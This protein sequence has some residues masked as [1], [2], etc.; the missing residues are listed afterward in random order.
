ML[1][2]RRIIAGIL[3]VNLLAGSILLDYTEVN[4][5]N[6]NTS[7]NMISA[8]NS[9]E[10]SHADAESVSSSEKT[11]TENKADEK[12][13]TPDANEKDTASSNSD[14]DLTN[15]TQEE[16]TTKQ[17]PSSE[18]AA[19]DAS[20]QASETETEAEAQEISDTISLNNLKFYTDTT[21]TATITSPQQ[22][23]LL[24]HCAQNEIQNK[25]ININTTGVFNLSTK[26]EKGTDL[27]EYLNT[28][29]IASQDYTYLGL[30]STDSPFKGTITGQTPAIKTNTTLFRGISSQA[31]IDNNLS[32][33]WL[34]DEPKPMFAETYLLE[35]DGTKSDRTI[36]ITFTSGNGSLLGTVK[37]A[38]NETEACLTIGN[39]VTYRDKVQAGSSTSND[40]IGLICNTLESG[41]IKLDGYVFPT[42]TTINTDS[43]A[44]G[45]LI[46][47]MEGGILDLTSIGGANISN[48]TVNSSS[49]SA[50]SIVGEMSE[51]AEIQVNQ[52][53]TIT[54]P[55]I[56]GKYAGG[57]AGKVVNSTL[58]GNNTI[59]V[60]AP[61]V[62]PG[63]DKTDSAVGGLIGDYIVKANNHT[64][65]QLPMQIAIAGTPKVTTITKTNGAA[66]GVNDG[67]I[68]GYFGV[69]EL[70][71]DIQYEISGSDGAKREGKAEYTAG[72]GGTYG[73]VIGK[74]ISDN[75]MSSLIINHVK[76][77]STTNG[78]SYYQGGIVGEIGKNVYLQVSDAEITVSNTTAKN[79]ACGFGGVVGHLS[80]NSILSIAD[81]VKVTISGNSKLSAGGGIVGNAS[82]GSILEISGTTDLSNVTYKESEYVGQLV[83]MQDCALIFAHGD[84]NGN[85]WKYIRSNKNSKN[86][87]INDIGNYGEV[88]R[89]KAST[90]I[91]DEQGG[92]DS[93][94]LSINGDHAIQYKNQNFS[95]SDTEITINSKE[96]LALLSIA[97]NS[98]GFFSADSNLTDKN[99][100]TLQSKNINFT[101]DVNLKN[102]GIIGISRDIDDSAYTGNINGNT[103]TLTLSIGETYGFKGENIATNDTEGCGK[104]YSSGSKHTNIGLFSRMGGNVSNLTITGSINA[105]VSNGNMWL[106]SIAAR[107]EIN[108]TVI[109][110]VQVTTAIAFD[111]QGD[112]KI[113]CIGG[114]FGSAGKVKLN[115]NTCIK[116]DIT[117]SNAGS[118]KL[119]YV[120]AAAGYMSAGSLECNGVTIG[121]K[122]VTDASMY[123]YVGGLVGFMPPDG[124]DKD[125]S[126]Q[127]N[128]KSLTF[129]GFSITASNAQTAC[130][131]LLGGVWARSAVTFASDNTATTT[132]LTVKNNTKIEAPKA[133]VGGLAY[134]ASGLWEIRS[135]GIDIQALNIN[136]GNDLGLLV[137]H[138]EKSTVKFNKDEKN[139]K[140]DGALYLRTTADWDDSYK[141]D[142]NLDLQCGS[143]A[144]F[145][146][147]VAYTAASKEKIAN[148]DENGIVSIATKDR[149]GVKENTTCK[150]YQNRTNFGKSHKINANSRYYYDLDEYTKNNTSEIDTPEELVLWSCAVYANSN[151]KKY[152]YTFNNQES[153]NPTISGTLNMDKYSYYPIHLN[154]G[155]QITGATITFY[156]E[157]IEQAETNNKSTQATTQSQHYMMHCGLFLDHSVNETATSI[158]LSNVTFAGSIGKVNSNA[159]GVLFSG[160]VQGSESNG[161]QNT[162]KM[163]LSN[164]VL[165]GL[166]ITDYTDSSYAPLLINQIG[167][168]TKTEIKNLSTSGYT[169][170]TA[171]ASSII[172]NA[173]SE[174]GH[175]IN[176]GF[177]EIK[178][179][180]TT[181]N[182]KGIFTHATLLES[183]KYAAND[184]SVATY[185][186]YKS[187]D[188]TSDGTYNHQVTYG[189]EI[190]H[191]TEYK[192]LQKWYYDIATYNED[193]GLVETGDNQTDFSTWLPYVYV[194]YNENNHSHEIKVNQRVFDITE[195]C[196]TYGD[197]YV[198]KDAGEMEIIS[199][200]MRTNLP[201]TDWKIT[202]TKEQNAYCTNHSKDITFRYN[203]VQWVEVSKEQGV[204]VQNGQTRSNSF[205]QR[206]IAN[207]YYDL[208]GTNRQ[209]TLNDF[210]GFGTTDNP[211]RGVLVS[212]KGVELILTGAN[213]G[214][215]L[216]AYSYGS[217]VKNLTIKYKGKKK[218]LVYQ[219]S[220]SV[221]Y[222]TSCFGGAIGCILG[223]DNII[224]GVNVT[225][226]TG[227]L[228]LSGANKHL[229]QVGGYVGSVCGGGVLFRNMQDAPGLTDEMISD[230]SGSVKET[231][232][233]SLYVNPYV[234]RVL[235]GYAFADT[236]RKSLNNTD[237]NYQIQ[238]L[239]SSGPNDT[240]HI[241][242]SGKTI[243]IKDAEGLLILSAIVNSGAASS[244][245]SNAYQKNEEKGYAFG[246]SKYAF[247]NG[248]YG[249]VRNATYDGIGANEKPEDFNTAVKDDQT[250]P[251]DSNTPVLITKYA[252]K[253]LFNMAVLDATTGGATLTFPNDG[254]LDMSVYKSSYQGISARYVSNA[255]T[256]NTETKA[257]GI[258]PLIQGVSGNGTKI[259]FDMNVRE[260]ADDDFH[261]ASVGG[262]F[263]LFAPVSGTCNV[264]NLTFTGKTG[265]DPKTGVQLQYYTSNGEVTAQAS[266][267]W[268]SRSFVGVG[269]FVGSTA[270]TLT[271]KWYPVKVN[272]D[273]V[274]FENMTIQSPAVAGGLIGNI[275]RIYTPT[276]DIGILLQPY[277]NEQTVYPYNTFT[278]CSFRDLTVKGQENAGGFC[279]CIDG[280][281]TNQ[282]N[283]NVT[284]QNFIVGQDS[285][286]SAIQ[287]NSS[288]GG[289]FGYARRGVAI[290][291]VSGTTYTAIWENVNVEAGQYSGGIIGQI[292]TDSS[293]P[294]Y[295]I[296]NV[297]VSGKTGTKSLI[298]VRSNG[299]KYTGGLI[300]KIS[301]A[302]GVTFNILD[303]EVQNTQINEVDKVSG[304]KL[305]TG[306]LAGGA[307]GN[308]KLNI[309][310][311]S[312]EESG[313][314]GSLVGGI[315]GEL[316]IPTTITECT[317]SGSDN[318]KNI[319]K[320]QKCA[321]GIVGEIACGGKIGI[322]NSTVSN[323]SITAIDD[324][325]AGGLVGDINWNVVPKLYFYD[326]QVNGCTIT[327]QRAGGFA[328]N[329]RGY[330][331]GS[332]LLLKD[333]TIKAS[334]VN[335]AGLLIGLTGNQN[336]QPMTIAGISIQKTTAKENNRNISKLYGT[337]NETDNTNVKNESYFSFADY[338]GTAS[339]NTT[340][341]L[342]DAEQVF[343]Y[344][345]TSPT[346]QLSVYDAANASKALYGDSAAW[347]KDADGKYTLNAQTIYQDAKNT[348]NST[349]EG[350]YTYQEMGVEQFQFT[351]NISTYNKE[352]QTNTVSN[353]FPVLVVSDNVSQTITDYLDIVTNGGYTRANNISGHVDASVQTYKDTGGK[354]V[355]ATNPA[356]EV[357]YASGRI[358][359]FAATTQYDNTQSRFTLLTVTFKEKDENDTVHNYNV[360]VPIIVRRMLEIGFTA[361]LSS[362]TNYR[363]T[364]YDLIED[365]AHLLES[366]GNAF[367][368]YLTYTYNSDDKGL[369]SEYGWNSYINAGGNVSQ[370]LDKSIDFQ[371]SKGSSLPAGTQLSL[372][373]CQDNS[374]VYYYT[375]DSNTGNTIPLKDFKDS[376]ENAFQAVSIGE[377]MGV[378]ATQD[379][380][381]TFIK[382]DAEGVPDGVTKEDGK[383]YTAPTVKIKTANGYEYYRKIETGE[384]GTHYA[385]TVDESKLKD[386]V[387]PISTVHENYYLVITV[388]DITSGTDLN[389]SV[390]T[391]ITSNGIPF[392]LNYRTRK[393]K[394][395]DTHSNTAS[396]YQISHGYKQELTESEAVTGAIKKVT[397]TDSSMTVDVVDKITIPSG[398]AFNEQDELYQK[399]SGSLIKTL[400][401]ENSQ[402]TSAEVFPNGTTGTAAFYVYVMDGTKKKYYTY[403]DRK[404]TEAGSTETKAL[405]YEWTAINGLMDLPLSTNGTIDSSVSLQ[406]IRK[407]VLDKNQNKFYVEVKMNAK[408]PANGLDVIPESQLKDDV[409][410][411]YTK[412]TYTSQLATTRKSLSYSTAR[413]LHQNTK[414]S[415]YR[416]EADGV[417][418]TYEADEIGQLGINL[419]DL[420]NSYLDAAKENTIIDTTARY[421]MS[422]IKDL[423]SILASSSG[424]QFSIQLQNKNTAQATE[425]YEDALELNDYNYMKV[426]VKS[427]KVGKVQLTDDHKAYTWTV[428]KSSYWDD[429]KKIMK[430]S[431][432]FDGDIMTQAIQLKV[433]IKNVDQLQHLYS[434]YRVVLSVRIIGEDGNVVENTI[435]EDNII[436]TMARV[437]PEFQD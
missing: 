30:G 32:V 338:N 9:D 222:P 39:V 126:T 252:D 416:D 353:D 106:G 315:A 56:K 271:S 364:N 258:V 340:Q 200:Y 74:V 345:V 394:V 46:G 223:G 116:S 410:T 399:F 421:D 69:L 341:S 250:A 358:S 96:D 244:G 64:V 293:S 43:G 90:T 403:A 289:L 395:E 417:Q 304:E 76:S 337:L 294:Y 83:G 87:K 12:N 123:A 1:K 401:Q 245:S 321:A 402:S 164:I 15:E 422:A 226:D 101:A 199:E 167:S 97:W 228:K 157:Q 178:L 254:T 172:G 204:D 224:D 419:L 352:N 59:T 377:L 432:I 16:E 342:L 367:T 286:I 128:I 110:N 145:D 215:G 270:G 38:T 296:R 80:S 404:W 171:V 266:N 390:Q 119:T 239:N 247:G 406:Q 135:K 8:E 63:V 324:W 361:T 234:G 151:I 391:K 347:T 348:Q 387:G 433:N 360:Q 149:N 385:V 246:N 24:S 251:S 343:P 267:N 217:V 202:I 209:I 67:N 213:T 255:V 10:V 121:G 219:K 33:E 332:N 198:I 186:F 117:L 357:K 168:Y 323:T 89:L 301:F 287:G 232:T 194:S 369:Y 95:L 418:L 265:T 371:V 66:I 326:S 380:N 160:M 256:S 114:L 423:S 316:C 134:K 329:I 23:I 276:T 36:P 302:S 4:A 297:R 317:V 181:V 309:Q 320:G 196:G 70:Q 312:V 428:P 103:H 328:G 141:L 144:V 216:I 71:G 173:G 299:E 77:N 177:S 191:S 281:V 21:K 424:I 381:G 17:E 330:L 264:T 208:Q 190:S 235:D 333:T 102:T 229:L 99:W 161:R 147:F 354:F 137:C 57:F 133:S 386:G 129:D 139:D 136:C 115:E 376:S 291:T 396:T 169:E 285:T 277:G 393:G 253:D 31:T 188:W 435:A 185:N 162:A 50:G 65:K 34:G 259:I 248:E 220:S 236:A 242:A 26:I 241:T 303:C 221:F 430:A 350:K 426:V 355:P 288:A 263:N 262:V 158:T 308:G 192:D 214:N 269:S 37:K 176:M 85:G 182:N 93:E 409:P 227:W 184:T 19:E 84:G 431:S 28:A 201:R 104:I 429:D 325:G 436:Y 207:A 112:S 18:I 54:N 79:E 189:K 62:S 373:D 372:I 370:A 272:F 41:T 210:K 91:S 268:G 48:L 195:G 27:S 407:I 29:A 336:L 327:G 156:N 61:T 125:T 6:V 152:F 7:L 86:F 45:G 374:K 284:T 415:Y 5:N 378:T 130:G 98:R 313:M 257:A 437:K 230:R 20:Q 180:D 368:A 124:S 300:G 193:E 163:N 225:L 150:T 362:G 78:N 412:L 148:N 159:S 282:N 92:L 183:Y 94:L 51:T 260:Y 339:N 203:G 306:G 322:H 143:N 58:S 349:A 140:E 238:N 138:G 280:K 166:K 334:A 388:A 47:K 113:S 109:S 132:S 249:K 52:N 425:T 82:S 233:R 375:T 111:A 331:N 122:I 351:K 240:K 55:T 35:S 275:A 165:S 60:E 278:N 153:S 231:E 420:Q 383:T 398:Q 346:S 120:G 53:I 108:E 13:T 279:G 365:N 14:S 205:M 44:A 305:R 392:H 261:A 408:L 142:A 356:L 49:G 411:N 179:P 344:V 335:N 170:G 283:L 11:D 175:Q 187:G 243:E 100:T 3:A 131:G 382:V 127:V 363:A 75:K 118:G 68:G 319:I 107:Q 314:Y 307:D 389:G 2:Y 405:E 434:N 298:K 413:A 379:N 397:A 273:S 427:E 414:I 212:T 206:Y 384:S 174:N 197:P 359:E 155:V 25:T 40:N 88:I 81:S 366:T 42:E 154:T 400:K 73:T 218:T 292:Y 105:G 72:D 274:K 318:D 310:N 146:E 211:F 22:L 290:N 295:K 311:C 237:K